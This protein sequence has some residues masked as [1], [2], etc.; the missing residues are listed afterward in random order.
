MPGQIIQA[1]RRAESKNVVMMLDE[2]DKVGA[3]FRG[4]PSAALLEVLDP[5]QNWEFSDHYLEVPYDLSQ[6]L[7][8]TTANVIDT[9]SPPLR[10]RMEIIKMAGYTEEEKLGIARN[11]LIPRQL[12]RH[13]LTADDIAITDDALRTLIRG[14]THEAGVRDLE[15]QIA[16]VMRRLPRMLTENTTLGSVIV[17]AG[18]LRQYLGPIRFENLDS[19]HDDAIGLVNGLVVSD[20]GGEVIVIEALAMEGRAGLEITGQIGDVMKESAHAGLSWARVNGAKYG[21]RSNFFDAH[22]IH[23]HVPAGAIPKEGPSAGV[24]MVVALISVA[25]ERPV[26]HDIAMTGEITLRGRVL[27]IG[28]VRDKLLAAK[29]AGVAEF[30]LPQ[31]NVKDM[32]DIESGL[33][34]GMVVTP[35]SNLDEVMERALLTRAPVVPRQP[36]GFSSDDFAKPMVA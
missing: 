15:R 36:M 3:D 27:P 14:Y 34:E 13:A 24:A 29:R 23:I 12:E 18:A 16:N 1:M 33:L 19:L 35:V 21:A 30:L 22:T 25:A 9:I 11:H 5:E 31:A 26:R 10:D 2:I 32:Y 8:I 6:V 4:D 28:G 7:F 20:V 17:D